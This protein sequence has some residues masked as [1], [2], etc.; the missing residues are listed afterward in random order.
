MNEPVIEV[1]ISATG[2]VQLK[3]VGFAGNTCREASRRIEQTL[4]V[5]SSDTPTPEMYQ[6]VAQTQTVRQASS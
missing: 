3:T 5:V 6:A 2:E 1:L 4:G